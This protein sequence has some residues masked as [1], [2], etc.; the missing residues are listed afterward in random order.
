MIRYKIKLPIDFCCSDYTKLFQ[1][2][3]ILIIK[4]ISK[5]IVNNIYLL[6]IVKTDESPG[7]LTNRMRNSK[8]ASIKELVIAKLS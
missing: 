3:V 2:I 5:L 8:T 6:F 7:K 4:I 1:S